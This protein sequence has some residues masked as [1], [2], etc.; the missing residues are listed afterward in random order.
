MNGRQFEDA[1]RKA[2]TL[3]HELSNKSTLRDDLT[4]Q[5]NTL[6]FEKTELTKQL[7]ASPQQLAT[8]KSS[9]T[10]FETNVLNLGT[11]LHA[12][13]QKKEP[14]ES[15]HLIQLKKLTT[16]YDEAQGSST[17][18]QDAHTTLQGCHYT[19]LF[20]CGYRSS[21]HDRA[22]DHNAKA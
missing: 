15:E 20:T 17:L 6:V 3:Q 4:E 12:A 21:N 18:L 16:K 13:Q 14:M 5:G 8:L 9:V 22:Y 10:E 1:W 2:S 11:K 7:D 19:G